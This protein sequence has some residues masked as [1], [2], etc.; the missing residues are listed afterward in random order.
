MSQVEKRLEEMGI[1]LGTAPTPAAEYVPAK[2]VNNLVYTSGADCRIN[3]KLMYEGKV[4][5][6][7]TVAQG[8]EASRQV[9][10]NLLSV[11]K[12]HIGDLDR[13]KQIVKLLGFVNSAD[14][15]TEQP[16]VING[17]SELLVQVFGEKGRHARSAISSNE[18]P[19]NTPV[20]IEM[21]VEL[22]E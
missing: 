9:M 16:Y 14:G 8:Y 1:V 10:V 3:G 17:A 11:L 5:S 2:T 4:G 13:V 18:L 12:G 21:I 20:E 15:F 6:D 7:L 19:F 22:E